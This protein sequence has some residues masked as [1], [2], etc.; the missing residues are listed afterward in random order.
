MVPAAHD[1]RSAREERKGVSEMSRRNGGSGCSCK[2]I[3]SRRHGPRLIAM[4][5]A[6]AVLV[7]AP[8]AGAIPAPDGGWKAAH[9]GAYR[10]AAQPNQVRDT[11]GKS[12]PAADVGGFQVLALD[13]VDSLKADTQRLGVAVAGHDRV[14]ITHSSKRP[15]RDATADEIKADLKAHSVPRELNLRM[16]EIE[17]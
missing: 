11:A 10:I 7:L 5:L 15:D 2:R 16:H 4:G 3:A 13:P 17:T 9:V 12:L 6:L 1:G 14:R 8:R